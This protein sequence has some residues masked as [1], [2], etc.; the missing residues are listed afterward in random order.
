MVQPLASAICSAA[1]ANRQLSRLIQHSLGRSGSGSESAQD[2]EIMLEVVVDGLHYNF[3]PHLRVWYA[4]T[5]VER[6]ETA[7]RNGAVIELHKMPSMADSDALSN[8]NVEVQCH[9]YAF[10]QLHCVMLSKRA[11]MVET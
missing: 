5:G 1:G 11:A 7:R 8:C 3:R 10:L 2:A 4:R 9:A 6:N